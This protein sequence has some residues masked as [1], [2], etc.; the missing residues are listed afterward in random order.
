MKRIIYS[1]DSGGVAVIIP[2]PDC[3]LSVEAIAAKDVPAGV[4]FEIVDAAEIPADRTFRGAWEKQGATVAH[5]LPKCK[6]IAHDMRR[7][8]REVEFAPLDAVIAKQIPGKSASEAEASRAVV[9]T[10][11]EAMQTAVDAAANV[12]QL[13]QALGL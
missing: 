12:D 11:Y 13:K 5:N 6:A 3:G 10:K 1:N 2:A 7:A 9:R 8:A 4:A